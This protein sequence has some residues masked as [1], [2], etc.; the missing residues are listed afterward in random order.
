MPKQTLM[1]LK[2]KSSLNKKN[3][4]LDVGSILKK[5]NIEIKSNLVFE[6]NLFCTVLKTATGKLVEYT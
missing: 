2:C 1:G 6:K 3:N 5:D 4:T